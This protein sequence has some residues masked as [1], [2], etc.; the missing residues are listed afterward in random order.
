MIPDKNMKLHR[1]MKGIG[2]WGCLYAIGECRATREAQEHW[3]G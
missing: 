1:G 2:H 3:S